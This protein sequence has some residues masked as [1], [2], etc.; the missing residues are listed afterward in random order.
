VT[1]VNGVTQYRPV[2]CLSRCN[3]NDSVGEYT[4]ALTKPGTRSSSNLNVGTAWI[5]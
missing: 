1:S 3:P 5:T 4:V 2:E